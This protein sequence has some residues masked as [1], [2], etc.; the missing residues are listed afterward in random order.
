MAGEIQLNGVSLATE[1]SGIVTVNAVKYP[2]GH[3]IATYQSV[4]TDT[5]LIDETVE[6]ITDLTL[7]VTPKL[8]PT[9]FLITAMISQGTEGGQQGMR[10]F[11]TKMVLF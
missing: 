4:K 1:S 7:T 6:L 10:V 11:F 9:K 3:V 8:N 5:Q 2:S